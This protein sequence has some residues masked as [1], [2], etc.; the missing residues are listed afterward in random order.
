MTDRLLENIITEVLERDAIADFNKTSRQPKK[1]YLAKL[2][3][4]VNE[5]GIPFSVWNKKN[6]DGSESK[7]IDCNSLVGSQ[8]KKLIK[9][10][11]SAFHQYLYPDSCKTVKQIWVDFAEYFGTI[12]DFQLKADQAKEVFNKAKKWVPL[13]CSL[14]GIRPGYEKCRV[15]PYM[16]VMVYH[17]PYFIQ[18]QGHLLN[19]SQGKVLKRIMTMPKGFFST[20][21]TNGTQPRTSCTWKAGSGI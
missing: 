20:N 11:P 9:G 5:I 2:V 8:K 16:H 12:S 10:L 15:T 13:F 6:A 1:I 19:D 21:Q 18:G 3:A 14:G 17:I 7:E 4:S